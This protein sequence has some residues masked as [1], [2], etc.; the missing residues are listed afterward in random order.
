MLTPRRSRRA[1]VQPPGTLTPRHELR[2]A[3]QFDR[4]VGEFPGFVENVEDI[5]VCVQEQVD[6]DVDFDGRLG[7][8]V[9]DD[10][11]FCVVEDPRE[12]QYPGGERGDAKVP[13]V[14]GNLSE[15]R[16]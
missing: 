1:I 3:E 2:V 4:T 15:V 12:G 14:T 5:A 7:A 13:S 10:E 6:D 9:R 16:P 8:G 11:H